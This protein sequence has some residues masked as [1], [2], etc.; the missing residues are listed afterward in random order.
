MYVCVCGVGAYYTHVVRDEKERG[1][2]VVHVMYMYMYMDMHVHVN[3]TAYR[4]MYTQV[5]VFI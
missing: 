3:S 4:Y 1:E 2:T 5:Q